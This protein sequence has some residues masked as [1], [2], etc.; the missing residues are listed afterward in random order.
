MY[1]KEVPLLANLLTKV[2]RQMSYQQKA[3]CRI[4]VRSRICRIPA[5]Q[6]N[7]YKH[8]GK[9]WCGYRIFPGGGTW[10][11][12]FTSL[13]SRRV[14]LPPLRGTHLTLQPSFKL[15]LEKEKFSVRVI[16]CFCE[17]AREATYIFIF[18]FLFGFVN[19]CGTIKNR[20]KTFILFP[21]IFYLFWY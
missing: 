5:H 17:F 8:F 12:T 1:I 15:L 19:F 9:L 11:W 2:L 13:E 20:D 10:T 16:L 21:D 6:N 14:C 4:S 3:D 7:N 18:G